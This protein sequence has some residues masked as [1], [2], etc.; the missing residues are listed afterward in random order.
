ME[1]R[2]FTL[3]R[4]TSN[5]LGPDFDYFFPE[6]ERFLPAL[7]SLGI[8]IKTIETEKWRKNQDPF[9]KMVK[10][11]ETKKIVLTLS[12][13]VASKDL[14][15]LIAFVKNK[16]KELYV[17]VQSEE[18]KEV[19]KALGKILLYTEKAFVTL[20]NYKNL[21]TK[22][23]PQFR[24]KF[25]VLP[26]PVHRG[27]IFD[28]EEAREIL[29]I[30][31]PYV[32]ICWG[33][34]RKVKGF[35]KVLKWVKH[36]PDTSLLIAGSL[37]NVTSHK[38]FLSSLKKYVKDNN[39]EKRVFFSENMITHEDIDIWFSA[40]DLKVYP[41]SN[42]ACASVTY[43]IGH[44]KCVVTNRH[45]NFRELSKQAG[46][47]P[48]KNFESTIRALL[49]N[50]TERK[51]QER[52]SLEYSKKWNWF[53]W[54]KKLV[55]EMN[56]PI[57][58]P[59]KVAVIIPVKN[60]ESFIVRHLENWKDLCYPKDR[61]RL[62]FMDGYSTDRTR[63]LIEK[64]CKKNRINYEIHLEPKYS[65]PIN[66]SGWIADTM[67][68][69]RKYLKDEEYVAIVDADIIYWNPFLLGQL[70]IENVD[71][72]A[73]YVYTE[74][75]G[76]ISYDTKSA[77]TRYFYD[78]T[79][80][81]R[82]SYLF[83]KKVFWKQA[84]GLIE[85]DSVGSFVL[86]KRE[87]YDNCY[88]DNPL[89]TLQFLLDARKL[90][91]R[92]WTKP[93][94]RVFHRYFTNGHK[95]IEQ[96]VKEGRLP[97][98]VLAKAPHYLGFLPQ[99]MIKRLSRE[100]T[101]TW[102]KLKSKVKKECPACRS[103]NLFMENGRV[104]CRGCG[105]NLGTNIE[106][107]FSKPNVL[108][109]IASSLRY[110]FFMRSKVPRLF[111]KG[112]IFRCSSEGETERALKV[113]LSGLKYEN[114]ESKERKKE[115]AWNIFKRAGYTVG[116]VNLS[117]KEQSEEELLDKNYPS[118]F[119]TF[120]RIKNLRALLTNEPFF[121]ILRFWSTSSPYGLGDF[122]DETERVYKEVRK[123][124]SDRKLEEARKIYEHGIRGFEEQMKVLKE[125]LRKRNLLES[126]LVVITSDYG[127]SLDTKEE[128]IPLLFYH[129]S[130]S[131]IHLGSC[132]QEDILPSILKLIGIEVSLSFDGEVIV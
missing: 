29:A 57:K 15:N 98:S 25:V 84:K 102:Q 131:R 74:P 83:P 94:A 109:I 48:T 81:R 49:E 9:K 4:W 38:R 1:D 37:E 106:E 6:K 93:K 45:P 36:W 90:G 5:R 97:K 3:I 7:Y 65:N 73:P 28:K 40:A 82:D 87:V 47:V 88:W 119:R 75:T 100:K 105:Y 41:H 17:L 26:Y 129:P 34:P 55:K 2:D 111:D 71:I 117:W 122:P 16:K 24:E 67:K 76:K 99:G 120:P 91:Y 124:L 50:P 12:E 128:H 21:F 113:L 63:E 35:D 92:I 107:Y 68:A 70:L 127:E 121:G 60:V 30:Q 115:T 8:R 101:Y 32:L 132:R 62:Y 86:V 33:C 53:E 13:W 11:I 39:L 59:P 58:K 61:F 27:R 43:A 22:M 104:W 114:L 54:T 103:R 23:Y 69:F 116:Y 46:I 42:F 89:P 123:L 64:Y 125:I 51:R 96:H 112:L 95:S 20:E 126:T 66:A 18:N 79:L 10:E 31:T 72:I 77:A 85:M 108:I 44:G 80:F 52:K 130:F 118:N 14:E 19:Q 78:C 56:I 110:D